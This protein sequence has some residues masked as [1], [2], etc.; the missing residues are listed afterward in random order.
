[1][2]ESKWVSEVVVGE[3]VAAA[4]AMRVRVLSSSRKWEVVVRM[5]RWTRDV[6]SDGG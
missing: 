1:M 2:R 3:M 6:T 5:E 4:A